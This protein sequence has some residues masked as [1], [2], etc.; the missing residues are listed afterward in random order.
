MSNHKPDAANPDGNFANFMM[1]LVTSTK[2]VLAPSISEGIAIKVTP[3]TQNASLA[4]ADNFRE[5]FYICF[6]SFLYIC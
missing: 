5:N 3:S 1:I 4:N 6:R 2:A